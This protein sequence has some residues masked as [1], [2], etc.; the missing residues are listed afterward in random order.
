MP[1]TTSWS[2]KKRTASAGTMA[3]RMSEVMDQ[4]LNSSNAYPVQTHPTAK[5]QIILRQPVTDPVMRRPSSGSVDAVSTQIHDP[6]WACHSIRSLSI[7]QAA[8]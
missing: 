6:C 1:L 4:S 8:S 3:L 5:E 7:G 2:S